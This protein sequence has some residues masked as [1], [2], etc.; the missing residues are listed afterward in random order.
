VNS[1]RD[2]LTNAVLK[3]VK[4]IM[5]KMNLMERYYIV[6]AESGEVTRNAASMQGYDDEEYENLL[7]ICGY[8]RVRKHVSLGGGTG[9]KDKNYIVFSAEA[10]HAS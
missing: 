6:D 1:R 10:G 2:K 7:R 4:E 9:E 3:Q 8:N 5:N